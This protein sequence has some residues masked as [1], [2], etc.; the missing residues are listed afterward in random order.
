VRVASEFMM[1]SV[2]LAWVGF[3][4]WCVSLVKNVYFMTSSVLSRLVFRGGDAVCCFCGKAL[5]VGDLV[6]RSCSKSKVYHKVCFGCPK[7]K[8]V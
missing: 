8:L 5:R 7:L 6:L 1:V 4:V 3:S 2:M